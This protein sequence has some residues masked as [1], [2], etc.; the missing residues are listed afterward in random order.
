MKYDIR[1]SLSKHEP[2]KKNKYE[3]KNV[4]YDFKIEGELESDNIE[5]LLSSI[6]ES[7]TEGKKQIKKRLKKLEK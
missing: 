2:S 3:T 4:Y 5:I 7:L 6:R 1:V